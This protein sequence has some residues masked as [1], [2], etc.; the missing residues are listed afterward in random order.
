[1]V[2]NA[3]RA[4]FAEMQSAKAKHGD[5]YMGNLKV[6]APDGDRGC[7]FLEDVI[8]LGREAKFLIEEMG[9]NSRF[10]VLLEEI[11]ELAEDI[12]AGR[13][14]TDELTQCAAMPLAWLG[15][16]P[17][18]ETATDL[19]PSCGSTD[20]RIRRPSFGGHRFGA[21]SNPFHEGLG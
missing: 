19:C 9:D 8:A 10:L 20:P 7:A 13:D 14:C 16:D 2:N 1:M 11:G 3:L 12:H 17:G 5:N 18:E 6:D 4:V 21:C 15:V